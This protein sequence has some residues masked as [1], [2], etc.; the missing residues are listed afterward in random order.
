MSGVGAG[1]AARLADLPTRFLHA[2]PHR[3]F[4]LMREAAP[5]LWHEPS[6]TWYVTGYDEVA[7]LLTDRR[8]GAKRD[9]LRPLVPQG[10]WRRLS[11]LRDFVHRWMV[12]SDPPRH[13]ALR[14]ALRPMYDPALVRDAAGAARSSLGVCDEP[15]SGECLQRAR[16]AVTGGLGSRLGLSPGEC[17]DLIGWSRRILAAATVEAYDEDVVAE[18]TAAY[19]ALTGFVDRARRERSGLL[20]RTVADAMDR[21]DI[22]LD[23][24]VG[25]YAQV[26]SGTL[27]PIMTVIAYGFERLAE[28]PSLAELVREDPAAFAWELSRLGSPFHI[29]PRYSLEALPLGAATIP[30]GRHVGLVVLAANRDPRRFPE[31]ER[32][33]LDRDPTLQLSF[34]RGRHAC[35]GANLARTVVAEA[36]RAVCDG[37]HRCAPK[38]GS[39]RISADVR[40]WSPWV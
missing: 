22:G 18:G 38:P 24:A 16:R 27:E 25:V 32:F 11:P 40:R 33:R 4:G 23:D 7:S 9:H 12:F 36:L 5:V 28:D 8:L 21:G 3:W 26:Y 30:A 6:S 34:G 35:L 37:D 20:A 14:R 19:E 1:L 17:A 13:T 31:P 2:D 15:G 29:A 39:W 10:V